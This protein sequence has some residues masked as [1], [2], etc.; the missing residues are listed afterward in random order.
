MDLHCGDDGVHPEILVEAL[1][2]N[3][4]Y[5]V[6]N[7]MDRVNAAVHDLDTLVQNVTLVVR[8][9]PDGWNAEKWFICRGT[10]A[11]SGVSAENSLVISAQNSAEAVLCIED[12][13]HVAADEPKR[14]H[15]QSFLD[16]KITQ[17][18]ALVRN[19]SIGAGLRSLSYRHEYG[20]S[21]RE[22]VAVGNSESD[23]SVLAPVKVRANEC[24]C[25][26]M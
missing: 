9:R 3:H 17:K 23:H 4:T 12:S 24:T 21:K 14:H 8:G 13:T 10:S 2:W 26:C 15:S 5:D 6:N 18:L 1:D 11:S 22:K 16:Q 19:R 25:V 20:A 7:I